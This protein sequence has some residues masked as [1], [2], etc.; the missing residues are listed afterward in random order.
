MTLGAD[1]C[2]ILISKYGKKG[3]SNRHFAYC[4]NEI[5]VLK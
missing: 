5:L 1:G 3:K 2:K 4:V